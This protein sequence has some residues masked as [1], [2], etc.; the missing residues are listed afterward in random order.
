M[1]G[2]GRSQ[3]LGICVCSRVLLSMS[4]AASHAALQHMGAGAFNVYVDESIGL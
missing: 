1:Q 2:A 3:P 4:M